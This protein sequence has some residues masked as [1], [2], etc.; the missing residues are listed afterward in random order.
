MVGD[1]FGGYIRDRRL[2]KAAQTLLNYELGIIDIAFSVR[3]NSHEAFTRS[4]RSCF[5]LSPKAFRKIRTSIILN[6]KPLLT[7]EL[8]YHL[9][10]EIKRDPIITIRK[11]KTIVGFNTTIPSPFIANDGSCD[12]LYLSWINFL[13]RQTEIKNRI[14]ETFFGLSI[15]ESENFIEATV[16]HIEVYRS[17]PST[18]FQQIWSH[19]LF[20]SSSLLCLK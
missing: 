5:N 10:K 17:H 20:L 3:F 8:L 16:D 12:L 14:P 1:T 7:T 15:S 4:F 2:T 11:E 6:E 19:A 9:A 18:K 13:E